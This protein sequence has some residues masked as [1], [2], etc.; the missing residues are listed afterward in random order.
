MVEI[1]NLV[2]KKAIV[3]IVL[4]IVI[5]AFVLMLI[6]WVLSLLGVN[7]MHFA[8][9]PFMKRYPWDQTSAAPGE[10]VGDQVAFGSVGSYT[11]NDGN[12]QFMRHGGPADQTSANMARYVGQLDGDKEGMCGSGKCGFSPSFKDG[13]QFSSCMGRGDIKKLDEPSLVSALHGGSAN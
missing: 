7:V 13:N 6:R 1:T 2:D 4:A 3:S 5:A 12:Y 11:N 9:Y 10:F 8:D